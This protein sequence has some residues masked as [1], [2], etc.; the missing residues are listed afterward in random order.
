MPFHLKQTPVGVR[1]YLPDELLH[2]REIEK[3]VA[4]LFGLFG[5]S[6]VETPSF[7][8][9]RVL[10]A[11]TGYDLD[12]YTYQFTDRDGEAL[13]LRPEMTTPIA[14][15]VASRMSGSLGPLRLFYVTNV[16]RYADPSERHRREFRQAG[17]EL[18]GSASPMADAEVIALAIQALKERGIPGCEVHIGHIG[19]VEALMEGLALSRDVREKIRQLL[20]S[21]DYVMYRRVLSDSVRAEA[22]V[23]LLALLELSG[24]SEVLD[25]ASDL[26]A[27]AGRECEDLEH[28]RKVLCC[29]KGY[30]VEENCLL[31]LALVKNFRYYT[32]IV[33]E[34]Y[35]RGVGYS[36]FGGGRYDGLLSQFGRDTPSTGFA[37]GI[38]RV[39]SALV[40]SGS[41]EDRD[42]RRACVCQASFEE[43]VTEVALREISEL[44]RLGVSIRVSMDGQE[45]GWGKD[46]V[47]VHLSYIEG[48]DPLRPKVV[49][50]VE[51][52]WAALEQTVRLV[53]SVVG[54]SRLEVR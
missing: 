11:S 10:A 12:E 48:L 15:L 26:L 51:G 7:E 35:A 52:K 37:M 29:L 44:R 40:A 20:L 8:F 28:L 16:F 22:R 4:D 41:R 30:G 1:D 25:R 21:Q 2:R 17:V 3:G 19:F 13:A 32:G 46:Q 9:A 31:D 38:E 47:G 43:S 36:L 50:R 42:Y 49:L 54:E 14:R 6:E 23:P 34:G 33:F 27:Q 45:D 18:I 39:Q 5:Y 24:G 53:E